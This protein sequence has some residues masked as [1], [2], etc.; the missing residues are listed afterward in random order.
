MMLVYFT[1]RMSQIGYLAD[2]LLDVQKHSSFYHP[3]GLAD[4]G[5]S[6]CG[7][8]AGER[9]SNHLGFAFMKIVLLPKFVSKLECIV[10][11]KN[12]KQRQ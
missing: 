1:D 4:Y 2:V 7:L 12:R 10:T 6:D 11:A 8:K 3:K 5:G 9:Y